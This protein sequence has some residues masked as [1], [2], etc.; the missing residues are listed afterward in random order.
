MGSLS[1]NPAW[2]TAY[3]RGIL[4][5]EVA[6]RASTPGARLSVGLF[7]AKVMPVLSKFGI[8]RQTGSV[9]LGCIISP[10]NVT[11]TSKRGANR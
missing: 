6:I 4:S 1:Q 3:Y 5:A 10:I 9:S 11:L 2:R 8:E 7:K